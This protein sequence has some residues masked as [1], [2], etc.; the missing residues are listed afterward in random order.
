VRAGFLTREGRPRRQPAAW[1]EL[2]RGLL[3]AKAG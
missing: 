1:V 3:G 2:F